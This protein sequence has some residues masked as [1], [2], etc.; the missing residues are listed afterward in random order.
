MKLRSAI[1]ASAVLVALGIAPAAE[2]QQTQ[3]VSYKVDAK[4]SKYTQRN[5][6]EVGDEMGH[7]VGSFEIHRQFG[8]DAPVINGV[9]VKETWTRGYSDYIK[10]NGTS[11]N[12]TT[13]VLENGDKFYTKSSTMGQVDASGKRKTSGVGEILGGTGKVAGIKGMVR[14]NGLSD[15]KAGFNETSAEIEYWLP[16]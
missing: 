10:S 13:Y 3:K 6:L 16:K 2:A 1:L 12:Y 11:V 4:G 7:Q 14:A 9:K 8:A 15:G 5:M